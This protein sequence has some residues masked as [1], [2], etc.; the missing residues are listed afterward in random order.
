MN[1]LAILSSLL[2]LCSLVIAQYPNTEWREA[3]QGDSLISKLIPKNDDI[4]IHLGQNL[5]N[6]VFSVLAWFTVSQISSLTTGL[7]TPRNID[8]FPISIAE[9]SEML[10]CVD[11]FQRFQSNHL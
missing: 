6:V 2:V 11:V 9:A 7:N 8:I 10:F 5:F 3:R 4:M 1:S